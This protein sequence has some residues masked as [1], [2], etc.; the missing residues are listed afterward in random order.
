MLKPLRN[1]FLFSFFNE[2]VGGRIV[3]RNRQGLVLINQG[4]DVQSTDARWGKVLAV[5]PETKDIKV[6]DIVLIEYGK[7]T[8]GFKYDGINVWKSDE[9]KVIAL[10][11][12]ESVTFAY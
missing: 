12:D 11:D 5:G 9:E 6:G 3:E 7:W 10:G 1:T 2:T 4:T 8:V